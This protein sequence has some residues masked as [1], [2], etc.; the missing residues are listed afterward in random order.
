MLFGAAPATDERS[1]TGYEDDAPSEP[2]SDRSD[3]AEDDE[4]DA[5]SP[6]EEPR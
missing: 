6:D 4:D 1:T 2:A 3:D 5:A